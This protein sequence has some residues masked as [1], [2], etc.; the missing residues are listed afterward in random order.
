MTT[1]SAPGKV[2][3][4][5][6]HAVVYGE[7]A[8]PCAIQRRAR[9]TVEERDDD[10]LQVQA[11][12][13]TLDGFTVT[14]GGET[15]D[16]PDVDVPA[17]LV[18]AAMGYIDGA[19]EQ[20]LDAVDVEECGFDIT[21]ESDIPL[22]AG[23]GSSAA[24]VVAGIDAAVRELGGELDAQAVAERA[25]E[26][27]YEVQSGEASRAD[28]FCSA[29][30]GAVRVRGD[31]C[32][33]LDDVPTLPFVVGYDGGTG[34]TG[35]LVAGVRELREEYDFAADTVE[36]IGDIVRKGEAALQRGDIEEVGRLMDFNHG[37]L[38]ALG[39]SA[40]S[41][42]TMVWAAREADALGAKLTGAGGGGCIVALDRTEQTHT[43]LE[44][45]PGCETAFRA[46]LDTDGVRVEE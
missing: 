36:S 41:L 16:R 35:E 26:V 33:R 29:V 24:V 28:T 4:F 31:D 11:N 38:S 20:A 40:R 30:G 15:N 34:D 9:V 19:I 5:G 10:R 17:P 45:T 39:V 13:L 43:A 25:Y 6:E 1:S 12:D 46:A 14:W 21:V 18:E 2:Y 44:Y 27:E 42:D 37:L 32:R 3:L 22:G 23:L 7:P 8:V